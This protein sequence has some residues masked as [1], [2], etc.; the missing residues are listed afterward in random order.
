MMLEYWLAVSDL[1]SPARFLPEFYGN[2]AIVLL[3]RVS[4]LSVQNVNAKAV[5]VRRLA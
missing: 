2:V 4:N 3:Q 1:V 5:F